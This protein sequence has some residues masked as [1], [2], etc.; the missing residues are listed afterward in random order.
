MPSASGRSGS[1]IRHRLLSGAERKAR[2]AE[3]ARTTAEGLLDAMGLRK[4]SSAEGRAMAHSPLPYSR[5]CGTF[6]VV[7]LGMR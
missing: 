4:A 6:D 1:L 2:E 7:R 3:G 5:S